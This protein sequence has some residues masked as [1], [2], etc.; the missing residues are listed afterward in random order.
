MVASGRAW[1]AIVIGWIAGCWVPEG[2]APLLVVAAIAAAVGSLALLQ[3][4]DVR[5]TRRS[6]ATRW[7]AAGLSALACLSFVM[8]FWRIGG[9]DPLGRAANQVSSNWLELQAQLAELAQA[10]S[11]T[12]D[13]AIERS[14]PGISQRD[15][16]TGQVLSWRGWV[17]DLPLPVWNELTRGEQSQIV[18]Y[19]RGVELRLLWWQPRDQLISVSEIGLPLAPEAGTLARA[20][21]TNVGA[22]ARWFRLGEWLPALTHTASQPAVQDRSLVMLTNQQ[23]QPVGRVSLILGSLQAEGTLGQLL[24]ALAAWVAPAVGRGRVGTGRPRWIL[25]MAVTAVVA[26]LIR[27]QS[28]GLET[29]GEQLDLERV[30]V[31][32]AIA[33]L[34]LLLT[35]RLAI[36]LQCLIGAGELALTVVLIDQ[37]AR[38]TGGG[39]GELTAASSPLAPRLMLMIVMLLPA[40]IACSRIARLGWSGRV[41]IAAAALG[42]TVLGLTGWQLVRSERAMK[43]TVEATARHQFVNRELLW[44]G[45]LRSALDTAQQLES[46]TPGQAPPPL[47]VWWESALAAQ[48]LISGVWWIGPDGRVES[49]TTGLP[50]IA[51]P[52]GNATS[53]RRVSA[54]SLGVRLELLVLERPG[55]SGTWIAAVL[56]HPENVSW[57]QVEDPLRGAR[58][59]RFHRL[60]PLA[61]PIGRLQAN[62]YDA[63]GGVLASEVE[64]PAPV[65]GA[66][67]ATRAWIRQAHWL[68]YRIDDRDGA[69]VLCLPRTPWSGRWAMLVVNAL[70]LI[71]VASLL[72]ALCVWLTE[73]WRQALRYRSRWRGLRRSLRWQLAAAL[74]IAGV[75]PLVGLALAGRTVASARETSRELV[76]ATEQARAGA[77]LLQDFLALGSRD[78]SLEGPDA[79]PASIDT[80]AAA[81]IAR[82][83]GSDLYVWREGI[84][85]ATNRTDLVATGAWPTRLDGA[86]WERLESGATPLVLEVRQ[87]A[88]ASPARSL[89]IAH[90]TYH[91]PFGRLGAVS[92]SLGDPERRRAL[93][94]IEVDRALLLSFAALA[95]LTLLL[96]ALTTGRLTAPLLQLQRVTARIADGQFQT[97]IPETGFDETRKLARSLRTMA[98]SLGQQ[99]RQLKSRTAAIETI[100]ESMPVAVLALTSTRLVAAANPRVI[101]LIGTQRIGTRLHPVGALATPI[102]HAAGGVGLLTRVVGSAS[103]QDPGRFR[104]SALDLPVGDDPR[105]PARLLIVEDLT[106]AVRAERLVA[107]A[108][109]ARRIAHEIKNPLTPISLIVDHLGKLALDHDPRLPDALERGLRTISEQVRV[110]RDTASEFSDY[111]RLLVAE[112]QPIDLAQ[113]LPSWLAAYRVALP[114][115]IQLSLDLPPAGV[116]TSLD[117]RLLRRALI[118]VVENAVVAVGDAGEVRVRLSYPQTP[119]ETHLE[120]VDNGPGIDP[121]QLE[122]LF[123]PDV[124]TR[125]TGSGLGLPIVREAV[126]AIGGRLMVDPRPGSGARF[127]M[128]FPRLLP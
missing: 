67:H 57:R 94:L 75:I 101:S 46:E 122:R 71:V 102:A 127:T 81:W 14:R 10:E 121:D 90:G 26:A 68:T 24:I 110:L 80:A 23:G 1:V 95:T 45:A 125:E 107:W 39:P 92:V 62:R 13:Q 37:V 53:P 104:I 93:G 86:E 74:M 6:S 100:I 29:L 113:E 76:R 115:T 43:R 18:A 33:L 50:P 21:P 119:P 42:V 124:T 16:V 47:R 36:W 83:L 58:S 103:E 91:E 123:E 22:R 9:F 31:L 3:R 117:P 35:R 111:A 56:E 4:G 59:Q 79:A 73:P 126:E 48:G 30:A 2:G 96:V 25:W 52:S 72:Q 78:L 7:L 63:A 114:T 98:S 55:S 116:M 65:P 41:W 97:T 118:N 108:E 85:V 11:F 15:P 12:P 34:V 106:D 82:A 112:N 8:Q 66:A 38:W 87:P 32:F 44:Q 88:P 40:A 84:L 17:T 70:L 60:S 99:Q 89:A 105:D 64:L 20:L 28:I 109:M 69:V 5:P 77:T 120:I 128:I 49:F 54:E 61:T 19:Q 27:V 51:R